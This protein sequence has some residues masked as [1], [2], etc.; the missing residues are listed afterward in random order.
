M[1]DDLTEF[2]EAFTVCPR[3][4]NPINPVENWDRSKYLPVMTC[5]KCGFRIGLSSKANKLYGYVFL[6]ASLSAMIALIF[7][8]EAGKF[9]ASLV[10]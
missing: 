8:I 4:K 5:D 9:L 10:T 3:C 7:G 6:G 1:R 2:K